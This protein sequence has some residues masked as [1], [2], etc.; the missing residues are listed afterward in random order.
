MMY[1]H[2]TRTSTR[3]QVMAE[4][5]DYAEIVVHAKHL[6]SA[7]GPGGRSSRACPRGDLQV[8]VTKCL[9]LDPLIH[10]LSRRTDT[11]HHNIEPGS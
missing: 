9:E 10:S 7:C 6:G 3:L 4:V 11:I 5:A 8:H 1:V 2:I